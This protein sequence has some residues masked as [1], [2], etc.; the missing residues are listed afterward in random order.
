ME[1]CS[2]SRL[3]NSLGLELWA[4]V[5]WTS[6]KVWMLIPKACFGLPQ[7]VWRDCL[8][9]FC[10]GSLD[11]SVAHT[12]VNY[13]PLS[14]CDMCARASVSSL[15]GLYMHGPEVSGCGASNKINH[16]EEE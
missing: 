10:V 13:S 3:H 15:R 2:N 5:C 12:C 11:P 4:S 8:V 6:V 14:M 1:N 16:E 7:D 9:W